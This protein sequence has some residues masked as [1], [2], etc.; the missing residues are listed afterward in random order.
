MTDP[1]PRDEAIEHELDS[2][3]EQE[4]EGHGTAKEQAREH[5][6]ERRIEVDK[7]SEARIEASEDA[8]ESEYEAAE[9]FDTHKRHPGSG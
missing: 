2:L 7:R 6:L 9:E 3:H 1:R 5:Q 8:E 4:E